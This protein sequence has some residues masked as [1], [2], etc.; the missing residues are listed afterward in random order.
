MPL[1]KLETWEHFQAQGM[2]SLVVRRMKVG[3][4]VGVS[5]GI[6]RGVGAIWLEP[7]RPHLG[8]AMA[9]FL[10]VVLSCGTLY[11]LLSLLEWL[12]LSRKFSASE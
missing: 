12:L 9:Q 11:V 1:L 6:L 2:R 4:A 8:S 7:R 5:A 3:L 10:F